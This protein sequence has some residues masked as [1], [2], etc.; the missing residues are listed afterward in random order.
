M[1]ILQIYIANLIDSH[2]RVGEQKN[3]EA[4]LFVES[5]GERHL[6][7][8]VQTVLENDFFQS[9]N[10]ILCLISHQHIPTGILDFLHG[11]HF[12]P[13]IGVIV[14]SVQIDVNKCL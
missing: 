2:I 13:E 6:Q 11:H 7:S 5:L 10:L 1:F 4:A 9:Q 14:S 3:D 8:F 12:D